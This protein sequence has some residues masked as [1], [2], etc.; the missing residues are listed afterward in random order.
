MAHEEVLRLLAL[1]KVLAR[2]PAAKVSIEGFG[3]LPGSEPLMVGIAK[4][5]AKTAQI[6]LAKAGVSEDRVTVAFSDM[7][8]DQRLARSI[9]VST[10]PPLSEVEKP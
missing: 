4:H 3:D 6:L 9:R 7:G 5:R 2:R 10:T 1:G 8:S